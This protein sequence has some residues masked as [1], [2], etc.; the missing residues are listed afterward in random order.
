MRTEPNKNEAQQISWTSG[1]DT[2][3]KP[4]DL[5]VLTVPEVSSLLRI[6]ASTIYD[7]ARKKRIR[8]VKVGRHWR[9]LAKEVEEYLRGV[10]RSFIPSRTEE[11]SGL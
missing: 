4:A 1:R 5:R 10:S 6:P 8:A 9:F 2:D 11:G 7:L 3:S